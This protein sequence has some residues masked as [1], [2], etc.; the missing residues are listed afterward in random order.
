MTDRGIR[1]R[2]VAVA[3]CGCVGGYV[4][5]TL[6]AY[7][8]TF[9]GMDIAGASLAVALAVVAHARGWARL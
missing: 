7:A 8:G 5:S 9:P 6:G 3:A 1:E 4:A 2:L